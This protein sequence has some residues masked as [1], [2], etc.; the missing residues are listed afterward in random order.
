MKKSIIALFAILSITLTSFGLDK[1]DAPSGYKWN[2]MPEIKGACLSPTNWYFKSFTQK[3]GLVY[4]ASPEKDE[5]G[6]GF[7]VGL[8]INVI[9]D[10]KTKSKV[11][12][13]EYAIHYIINYVPSEDFI[14]FKQSETFG[15]FKISSAELIRKKDDMRIYM[16]TFANTETDTLYVIT[17]GAPVS[18]WESYLPVKEQVLNPILIDD[19]I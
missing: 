9:K 7:D 2:D 16:K 1:P 11:T 19:E 13:E 8:S 14:S 12:A 6:Q 10:V 15:K 17:F 5:S 3:D 4:T 18:E